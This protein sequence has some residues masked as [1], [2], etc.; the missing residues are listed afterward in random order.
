MPSPSDPYQQRY[1]AG[2]GAGR[3]RLAA[4]LHASTVPLWQI[5]SRAAPP[6]E[7]PL[8]RPVWRWYFA[9]QPRRR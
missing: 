4:I 9:Q 5:N 3:H 8:I 1:P 2:G 6:A 7:D